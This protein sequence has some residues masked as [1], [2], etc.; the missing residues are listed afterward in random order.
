MVP[1]HFS[2]IDLI[3]RIRESLTFGAPIALPIALASHEVTP[4][5]HDVLSLRP[6]PRALLGG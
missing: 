2:A 6:S 3:R 4:E 1:L 5:A